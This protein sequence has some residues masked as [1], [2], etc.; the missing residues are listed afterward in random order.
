MGAARGKGLGLGHARNNALG[1]MARDDLVVAAGELK[2]PRATRFRRPPPWSP[3]H[4]AVASLRHGLVVARRQVSRTSRPTG[5]TRGHCNGALHT[6]L[7]T[8]LVHA[9]IYTNA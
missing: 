4:L 3:C 8:M 9:T 7:H 5:R 6:C 2:S 1:Y